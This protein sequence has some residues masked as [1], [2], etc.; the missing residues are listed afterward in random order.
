MTM[1]CSH[2][3]GQIKFSLL[4]IAGGVIT[5]MQSHFIMSTSIVGFDLH[6]FL[7]DLIEISLWD[8]Y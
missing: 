4:I 6:V 2:P 3:D 7:A 5:R 8:W 1:N